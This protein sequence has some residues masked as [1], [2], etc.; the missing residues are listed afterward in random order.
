MTT[1]TNQSVKTVWHAAQSIKDA[2]L[3]E[4]QT[5]NIRIGDQTLLEVYKMIGDIH[6]DLKKHKKMSTMTAEEI[7]FIEAESTFIEATK[8]N[9]MSVDKIEQVVINLLLA[10]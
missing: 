2:N 7:T 9:K 10:Y 4:H 1:I 8:L 6:I 3:Q 5:I